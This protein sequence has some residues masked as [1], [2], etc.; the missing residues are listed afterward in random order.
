MTKRQTDAYDWA[1]AMLAVLETKSGDLNQLAK[2]ADLDPFAGDMS[3][4]DCSDLDLSGQNLS[5]W[6]LKHATFAGARLTNT[7]LRNASIDPNFL[8]EADDWESAELDDHVRA[9]ATKLRLKKEIDQLGFNPLFLKSIVELELSTKAF[10]VLKNNNIVYLGDLVEKSE[11]ALLRMPNF[12]RKA[13]N[14]MKEILA[15][16]GLHLGVEIPGWPP[17][18]VH[19]L[20]KKFESHY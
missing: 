3:D 11:A 15:H 2:A 4:M 9:E 8:I 18:E 19:V 14:E 17:E 1:S 16:M 12:G 13:V 10:N 7:R 5:G 6:D 20:A